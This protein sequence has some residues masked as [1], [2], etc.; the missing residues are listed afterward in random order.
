MNNSEMMGLLVVLLV[1]L[2]M[3]LLGVVVVLL[4][5]KKNKKEQKQETDTDIIAN[6]QGEN[7]TEVKVKEK[8][9]KEYTKDSIFNFMEFDKIEDNMIIQKNGMRYL[10]V[11]ECQGVNY[12]LL[13]EIEKVAVEEGFL[14]FLNSLRYPVQLYVQ[15][16]TVNLTGSIQNYKKKMQE[17]KSRLDRLNMEFEQLKNNPNAKENIMKKYAFEILKQKNLYEYGQDIV[18]NTQK[19]N[20]N[21]N[22]LTKK[23]YIIIPYY[24]EEAITPELDMEEVKN[25]AFSE[26]YTR[27]QAIHNTLSM[28]EVTSKVLNSV[29]LINLLYVA[30]NRDESET[31]DIDKIMRSGCEDIYSTAPD[32]FERKIK[33]LDEYIEKQALEKAQNAYATV[34]SRKQRMAE[35]KEDKLDQLIDKLAKEFLEQNT[36]NLGKEAVEESKKVIEETKESKG[37][38]SANEKG[39][40]TRAVSTSK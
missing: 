36:P 3:A 25:I 15:S 37:G 10:M 26:L 11:L 35:E 14:Q 9:Y 12:D 13:S 18:E 16:R 38:R 30:Y 22:I 20:L 23:Y 27:A 29:D 34:K 6:S 19:M 28:C 4:L 5:K 32:V 1:F 31:F 2:V 8:I 33:V 17:H 39:K 21:K 7:T 24:S 40:R